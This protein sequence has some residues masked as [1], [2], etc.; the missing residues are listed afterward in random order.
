MEKLP[1]LITAL[2]ISDDE[3]VSLDSS[4]APLAHSNSAKLPDVVPKIPETIIETSPITKEPPEDS[5]FNES[6]ASAQEESASTSGEISKQIEIQPEEETVKVEKKEQPPKPP[7][8]KFFETTKPAYPAD[9][10]KPIILA[11]APKTIQP[12]RTFE[13][14]ETDPKVLGSTQSI[15]SSDSSD[16]LVPVQVQTKA[17]KPQFEPK[18]SSTPLTK[19]KMDYSE[20]DCGLFKG[21]CASYD[22]QKTSTETSKVSPTNSI[23][24]AKIQKGKSS[25]KK[26]N[27]IASEY[28]RGS[29]LTFTSQCKFT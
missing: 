24:K 1:L 11:D 13:F 26:N 25:K 17:P 3:P 28:D 22:V 19:Y 10:P 9:S 27:L 18:V 15:K 23:V 6:K 20:P 7:P 2:N 29:S 14:P 12:R 16:Y 4:T 8:R 21:G 5:I